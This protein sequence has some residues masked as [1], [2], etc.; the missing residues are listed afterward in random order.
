MN[1]LI[2]KIELLKLIEPDN[3]LR[4]VNVKIKNDW[5]ECHWTEKRLLVNHEYKFIYCPIYKIASSSMML[6]M[7]SL[8]KYPSKES[9]IEA[10]RNKI[11]TYI[12]LNYSMA[13]YTYKKALEI[14]KSNYFKFSIVRNPWARL[15]SSYSNFFVQLLPGKQHTDFAKQVSKIIYG[16]N[17]YLSKVD[18]ITFKDF[19]E[20]YVLTVDDSGLNRH[21]LPQYIYLGNLEYDFIAKLENLDEDLDYIR[22]KLMLPIEVPRMNKT[23]YLEFDSSQNFSEYS[24]RDIRKLG[25]VPNYKQ[26]FTAELIDA[27]ACR[28]QHDIDRFKYEF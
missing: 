10:D 20:K 3:L 1:N 21:C 25:F 4:R 14:I 7:L 28:Y 16:E 12:N 9:M 13:N 23:E 18:L 11:R 6:F 17:D 26:F 2:N 27:V 15:V 5:S 24:S 8:S 22:N 19:V